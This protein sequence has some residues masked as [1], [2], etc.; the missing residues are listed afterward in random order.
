MKNK[1]RPSDRFTKLG[2]DTNGLK[3]RTMT[4]GRPFEALETPTPVTRADELKG[5]HPLVAPGVPVETR[6]GAVTLSAKPD[7]FS[8]EQRIV[9][10]TL[11]DQV[12]TLLDE[13]LGRRLSLITPYLHLV[14]LLADMEFAI[15]QE[16][17]T[18]IIEGRGVGR[19]E[20]D[21]LQQHPAIPGLVVLEV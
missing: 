21:I 17:D 10:K 15:P 14:A 11:G 13:P 20:S 12:L 4:L 1:R 18:R 3:N 2:G 7:R 9:A 8:E 5:Q 6:D 19:C 16:V